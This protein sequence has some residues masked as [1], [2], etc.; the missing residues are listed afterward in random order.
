MSVTGLHVTMTGRDASLQWG[1]HLAAKLPHWTY[2]STPAGDRF[3]G[4]ATEIHSTRCSQRPLLLCVPRGKSTW[5]YPVTSLQIV[6][7]MM[8]IDVGP[9]VE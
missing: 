8:T 1:Y 7:D 3:T 6:G 5:C 4:R 9:C 2:D